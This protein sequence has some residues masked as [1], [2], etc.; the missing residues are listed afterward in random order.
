[1]PTRSRR[2]RPT[3]NATDRWPLLA[4]M[5][6][7]FDQEGPLEVV[8]D[9]VGTGSTDFWGISFSPSATEQDR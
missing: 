6:S 9:K 4:G 7:E 3:A 5:Q 1:M 8:E 2:S